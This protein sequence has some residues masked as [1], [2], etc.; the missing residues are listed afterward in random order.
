MLQGRF[1]ECVAHCYGC[2][3]A[4][5]KYYAG[6]FRCLPQ[7]TTSAMATRRV[8]TL[9]LASVVSS[10]HILKHL[11]GKLVTRLVLAFSRHVLLLAQLTQVARH[12][13]MGKGTRGYQ[14]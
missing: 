13:E 3:Q 1:P 12:A 9:E 5:P 4:K 8:K 7:E 10:A 14:C 11:K 2:H 6:N